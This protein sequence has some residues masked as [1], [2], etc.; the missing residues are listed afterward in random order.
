MTDRQPNSEQR[1]PRWFDLVELA[2]VQLKPGET[3]VVKP[4]DCVG[5]FGPD[6]ADELGDWLQGQLP[7]VRVVVMP[8][9]VDIGV[10]ASP[11]DGP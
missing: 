11:E 6:A 7:D 3:L 5:W 9:Q 2:R 4:R 10:L 1:E 8:M